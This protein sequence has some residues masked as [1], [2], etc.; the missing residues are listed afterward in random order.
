MKW[1]ITYTKDFDQTRQSTIV[2]AP[3]Y[4]MAYVEYMLIDDGIILEIKQI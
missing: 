3:S 2:L 4:T 1:L